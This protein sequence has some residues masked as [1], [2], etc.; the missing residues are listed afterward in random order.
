MRK[1]C[2][3]LALCLITCAFLTACST[4]MYTADPEE[5]GQYLARV[6][7]SDKYM[8]AISSLGEYTDLQITY[9]YSRAALLYNV[10]TVGLF[11]TYDEESFEEQVNIMK[12]ANVFY[13]VYPDEQETDYVATAGGYDVTMVKHPY[14]NPV[15]RSAQL[16]GVDEENF[17]ICYL[18]YYDIS[19]DN[20]S[21]LDSYIVD[22]FYLK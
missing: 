16:I 12:A 7:D 15:Y 10:Y 3:L 1:I 9:K 22:S 5:Y 14:E 17:K 4:E 19:M 11:V 2:L 20:L 6:T 21:D 18:F 13:E 8:P